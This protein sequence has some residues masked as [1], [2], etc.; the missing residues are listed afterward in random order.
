MLPGL[1]YCW[2]DKFECEGH[3]R[4]NSP[5]SCTFFGI[6]RSYTSGPS[7]QASWNDKQLQWGAAINR[8][9]SLA[10]IFQSYSI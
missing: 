6:Q 3:K 2:F 9:Q 10:D 7:G 1:G 8:L 4:S 5:R